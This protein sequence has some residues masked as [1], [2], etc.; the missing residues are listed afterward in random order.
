MRQ[1]VLGAA[2][3]IGLSAGGAVAQEWLAL[4]AKCITP[5]IVSK[6]GVGTANAVA[7]AKVSRGDAEQ[8]CASWLPDAKQSD[9][10]REQLATDEAKQ[11]YRASADC[12]AGRIT[13]IDGKTYRLDGVWPGGDIGAGR[14]RFR[15]AAGRVVGRDNASGGLGISQQWEVLCPKAA[16]AA[17]RQAVP[18]APRQPAPAAQAT[19]AF[20]V[21]QAIEAQYGRD[22]VRGQ[23]VGIRQNSTARGTETQYEVVLDNRRRGIV[24]ARML[25]SAGG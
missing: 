1:M 2:L 20:R 8:Y 12:I 10:V 18:P 17:A 23:V 11:T 22:W 3:A 15:N 13:P 7:T 14:V 16:P 24:P 19:P 21:G 4:C 6:S 5:G 25:R 9:C